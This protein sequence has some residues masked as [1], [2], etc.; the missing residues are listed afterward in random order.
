[1]QGLADSFWRAAA[2]CL[3]PRVI[4]LSLLPL[5]ISGVLVFGFMYFFWEDAI[6][7]V[8]ATLESWRLVESLLQWLDAWGLQSLRSALAAVVV[9]AGVV[10]VVLLLSLL[11]VALCMTPAIVRLVAERRFPLLEKK[12]GGTLLQSVAASLGATLVALVLIVLSIPL[13]LIPPLVMVLPPL[14]WGW[15]TY[16]VFG[17]DVLAEHASVEERRALL[18]EHRIPM[19]VMGVVCGYLGAAP[20]LIW[21]FGAMAIVFAPFLVLLAIWLYTLVFAFSTAW[22][23]HYA[24]AALQA[25]R[26]AEPVAESAIL[27]EA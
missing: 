1:M 23:A 7:G 3:H 14:I 4:A 8:R 21:A 16:R 19:L 15:L 11:L 18:R 2:Y 9:L 27:L 17:F 20:S 13:W 10:P 25:R 5:F 12:R 26:A 22:F 24:L 6:A